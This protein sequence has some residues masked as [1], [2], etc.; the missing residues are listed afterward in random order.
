MLHSVRY[1]ALEIGVPAWL[2]KL[3]LLFFLC[4]ANAEPVPVSGGPGHRGGGGCGQPRG[5]TQGKQQH[6]G[7]SDSGEHIFI[8]RFLLEVKALEPPSVL[9]ASQPDLVQMAA[10]QPNR[11]NQ[12]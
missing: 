10:H 9:S 12:I 2:L 5:H 11:L 4:A 6:Q 1:R 3:A 8:Y 7:S